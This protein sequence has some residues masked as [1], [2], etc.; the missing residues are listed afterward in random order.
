MIGQ[1]AR[2]LIDHPIRAAEPALRCVYRL[3]L[4][5]PA[6]AAS[7]FSSARRLPPLPPRAG[8]LAHPRRPAGMR[9]PPWWPGP[10]LAPHGRARILRVA[11]CAPPASS[12]VSLRPGPRGRERAPSCRAGA[13]VSRARSSRRAW[14]MSSRPGLSAPSPRQSRGPPASRSRRVAGC[15]SGAR[16]FLPPG[17][18]A[19]SSRSAGGW[20]R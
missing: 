13:P 2:A 15:A 12:P 16:A 3:L 11:R 4:P 8:R 9:R 14:A 1:A 10:S 5:R 19:A 20:R 6:P 17:A 7:F 18:R